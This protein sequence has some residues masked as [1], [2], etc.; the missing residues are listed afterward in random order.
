MDLV[1]GLSLGSTIFLEVPRPPMHSLLSE[2]MDEHLAEEYAQASTGYHSLVVKVRSNV[3]D[4]P[5]RYLGFFSDQNTVITAVGYE[6]LQSIPSKRFT[7]ILRSQANLLKAK[8][9]LFANVSSANLTFVPNP[10]DIT[11]GMLLQPVKKTLMKYV[12]IVVVVSVV[13]VLILMVAITTYFRHLENKSASSAHYSIASNV[14][15]DNLLIEDGKIRQTPSPFEISSS[16][17]NSERGESK[18]PVPEAKFTKSALNN[19]NNKRQ[20]V[21]VPA[22]VLGDEG[23][24]IMFYDENRKN[25]KSAA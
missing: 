11:A 16:Y 7:N 10:I 17:Y 5:P 13:G 8:S 22:Q 9:L 25:K 21:H 19:Y 23:D 20:I 1:I 24:I 15:S 4:L 18:T 12:S 6:I 14:S 3:R 2:E